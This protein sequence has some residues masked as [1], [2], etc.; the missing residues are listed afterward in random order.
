[1]TII[2]GDVLGVWT[3]VGPR[4][5]ILGRGLDLHGGRGVLGMGP[6]KVAAMMQPFAASTAAVC[7]SGRQ[8]VL[9]S[10]L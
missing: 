5:R 7:S 1:M 2:R 6:G 4:N 9:W 8:D 10:L 3:Q